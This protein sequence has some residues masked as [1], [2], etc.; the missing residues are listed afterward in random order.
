MALEPLPVD[1]SEQELAWGDAVAVGL[2]GLTL[3]LVV[4]LLVWSMS[5]HV[6]N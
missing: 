6:T 5:S 3:L 4:G 1:Y 2:W